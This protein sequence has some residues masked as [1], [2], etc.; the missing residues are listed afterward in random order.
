MINRDVNTFKPRRIEQG[1]DNWLE[2]TK[3]FWRQLGAVRTAKRRIK[4]AR[5]EQGESGVSYID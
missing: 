1:F 3:P 4:K 2:D 5:K